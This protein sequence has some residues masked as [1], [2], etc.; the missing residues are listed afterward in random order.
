MTEELDEWLAQGPARRGVRR[1]DVG[2]RVEREH[3]PDAHHLRRLQQHVLSP[4]AR[5]A[6]V[7]DRRQQL[8]HVRVSY[9]LNMIIRIM[10][11]ISYCGTFPGHLLPQEEL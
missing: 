1:G 4:E 8:L 10:L 7:P 6:L 9:E 11:F 5:H 2:E 3:G